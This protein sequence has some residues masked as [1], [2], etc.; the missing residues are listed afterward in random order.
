M[1][2]LY[3][4]AYA[5]QETP[6]TVSTVT[7]ASDPGADNT[8]ATGD[9]ITVTLTF[10]EAVTIDTTG[11]MPHV[12]LQIGDQP[13]NAN[14][15]GDGASGVAHPFSYTVLMSDQDADGVSVAAN[16]LALNGGTIR[17]TD[18][19]ADAVLTHAAASFASHQVD[20]RVVLVSNLGQPESA[21]T[22]TISATQSHTFE[23]TVPMIGEPGISLQQ[24][25]LDV[26]TPSDTLELT[27][28]AISNN[29]PDTQVYLYSGSVATGG[30]QTFTLD[31][32]RLDYGHMN[33]IADP[34]LSID[35]EITGTGAGSVEL[36]GTQYGSE[37]A[38]GLSGWRLSDPLV[39]DEGVFPVPKVSLEGYPS[40]I[41]ELVYAK[42]IS[43]PRN[44]TVYTAG[45]RIETMLTLN[46]PLDVSMIPPLTLYLGA[47]AEHRREAP[48]AAKFEL[49]LH[50]HYVFAYVVQPGDTDASG[51]YL[52]ANPWGSGNA[53]GAISYAGYPA[54]P[55]RVLHPEQQLGAGQAVDGTLPRQCM[56]VLC[57][58]VLAELSFD[59]TV[60]GWSI[61]A[62]SDSPYRETGAVNG[63]TFEYDG[64]DMAVPF[65]RYDFARPG[66]PS[67]FSFALGGENAGWS[68]ERAALLLD[69]R[70][71]PPGFWTFAIDFGDIV[72]FYREN[73]GFAWAAGQEIDVKLIET[74]TAS[75]AAETYGQVEGDTFDVTVRLD[76]A[77]VQTTVTVPVT[78]TA[79]GGATEADYSG[80]PDNLV[81]NPGESSQTFTVT[82][83]DDDV[84]DDGES[85]TLGFGYEHHIRPGGDH[86][87]TTIV[88]GD[89]DDPHVTVQFGQ[90]SQGVGEGE[91]VNV[92]VSLNADPERS[93][94]IPLTTA[95]QG[96]A[97]DS[98]FDVATSV[99]FN[100]GD[101]E[102][103]IAFTA[104]EDEED[105]DDESVKLGFGS[106]LPDRVTVGTR[107]ETTLDIGDDDDPEVTVMFGASALTVAEG[108]TQQVTVS[109]NADPERTIIIP[110]TTAAQGTI[111]DADYSGVP[112][113]VR[114]DSGETSASFT[115][116]AF[117]DQ[118]DDDSEGL[119]LGFGAMPDPRVSAATPNELSLSIAD[120]DTAEVVLDHA[121][122]TLEEESQADYTVVLATEP[123]VNVSVTITGHAGTDLRVSGDRL[124]NDALTFTPLNW[125][126]PQSVTVVPAHDADGVAD[127]ETLTHTATGA[128]Y[129][130]LQTELPVTVNDNDPLGILIE[131]LALTVAESGNGAYGVALAT[132]PTV[133][134]TLTITGHDGSDLTLD[135]DGLVGDT[136]SFTA[137]NWNTLQTVT[138][139]AAHDEDREDD[140]EFLT[141]T[142]SGG[143]YE[144]LS[145]T[146]PVTIDDNTGDL[147]LVDGTPVAEGEAPCD[148]RLEIYYDG[149]W[150]TICDDHW[151]TED[152]TVAC[153][154]L[155][156][157]A[158]SVLSEPFGSG[159]YPP[160][161]R[162]QRIWLDDM[163]CTGGEGHPLDCEAPPIGEHNCRHA[164]DVGLRCLKTTGPWI[165]NVEFSP[166]S[167]GEHY[168][169]GET[170]EVTLVWSEPVDVSTTRNGFPRVAL[171]YGG[172]HSELQH[173]SGSGSDRMVYQHTLLTRRGSS[174]FADIAI[175]TDSLTVQHPSI[176]HVTATIS[177]VATGRAAVLGH[178]TYRSSEPGTSGQS[179]EGVSGQSGEGVS[180][181]SGEG[182]SGQ[183]GEG[184]SG[185]SGEGVSG[186]SGEGVSGQSGEGASGQSGEG[187]TPGAPTNLAVS[188]Q[189][190]GSL[191]ATWDAPGSGPAPDGYTV[192]WKTASGDWQVPD[193]VSES[194]VTGTSYVISGLEDGVE[195][196]IRVFAT[197]DDIDGEPSTE[198]TATPRETRP[199]LLSTATVD[200]A[201]LTL[202]YDEPLDE[203][204]LPAASTFAVT[205]AGESR[206]VASVT[207]SGSAATLTLA[208]AVVAGEAVTVDYTA[209]TGAS[210]GKV[211]DAAGNAAASFSDLAVTND[212]AALLTA[213]AHDVPADH[214]GS[215]TTI[216]FELRFSEQF[217]IS[218]IT[219]RDRAFTVTDG[220]VSG[221]RRLEQGKNTRWEISVTPG[222]NGA[223]TIVLPPTTDCEK[224]GAICTG[225]GR[226][227]SNRLEFTVPG[228]GG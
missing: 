69:G 207:V 75:F 21:R 81:F 4:V 117:Q 187:D 228:P 54:V 219:L 140:P 46:K 119:Q 128:E 62:T 180:G 27:V 153:R 44:G 35:V 173:P 141:H 47:G 83:D 217:G 12:V 132:E 189:Q 196:A 159:I 56:E 31:S 202:T 204:T 121:S 64:A 171:L 194:D 88:L 89:N 84:D 166:P 120:D 226:M 222:G 34:G 100:A 96:G 126:M 179:G 94:I 14:Y 115:F 220:E 154:A 155:G 77:F 42:V 150:G 195:Y 144:G 148:G 72:Q 91:T 198:V 38:A 55:A 48:L 13:R 28:R 71:I 197:A 157:P 142:A 36:A 149:K 78:V 188:P 67:N 177:S 17:A 127:L 210:E 85:L 146:L 114:F 32:D 131:P 26:K 137:A 25:T 102:Q 95:K 184:V 60:A 2:G 20:T 135:G 43:S 145:A 125:N 163:G 59:S 167:G 6:P 170:V 5:Q 213:S 109:L 182:V 134:V 23:V 33:T 151:S 185:Q 105:D 98:D 162:G 79:R 101:L 122:L 106:S 123:T 201:E 164:E 200:G 70:R 82:V 41:P 108:A 24:I 97:Q 7:I 221:A 15:A 73:P 152:A 63:I 193:Q 160:G 227:L 18:D 51:I 124:S 57:T 212:T 209:P 130:G 45:E 129:D 138:V 206:A 136:L 223:V 19:S 169:A 30:L 224:E 22:V 218:Y 9:A 215:T 156:F 103:T 216:T 176:E 113:S 205:V 214:G 168:E 11:G 99:T 139:A 52:P 186:Q 147:R 37:D 192:Q 133:P 110:I 118:I 143:E 92:T 80:I 107:S 40:G 53:N 76:E 158:G 93:L 8:Y 104:N 225:D 199:P 29:R 211:Q 74:S 165:V 50:N 116:S 39:F 1:L 112:P 3:S 58:R 178:R 161:E 175:S 203:D 65:I 111:S 90:A 68:A 16:S 61:Y 49:T 183:S 87:T 66:N 181:Q 172:E 86:E 174:S 191:Q 10:S 190:S 208:T